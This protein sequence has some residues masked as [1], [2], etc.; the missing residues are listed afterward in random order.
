M[1]RMMIVKLF[2]QQMALKTVKRETG[3]CKLNFKLKLTV[4]FSN[5]NQSKHTRVTT[6]SN[7][8]IETTHSPRQCNRKQ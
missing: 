4:I 8:V 7:N 6:K 5:A 3:A 2:L 1:M